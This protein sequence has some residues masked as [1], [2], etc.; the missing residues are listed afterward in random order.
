LQNFDAPDEVLVVLENDVEISS[1]QQ[2]LWSADCRYA[3]A[4]LGI[5]GRDASDTYV[6]DVTTGQRVGILADAHEINHPIT[7]HPSQPLLLAETR[8]GALLWYL[9][10]NSQFPLDT[11]AETALTG[12]P[13]VRNFSAYSWSNDLFFI[14]PVIA[15]DT[16]GS[17]T[18]SRAHCSMLC[19]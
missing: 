10:T 12:R 16:Y 17:T 11:G 7:W 18:S 9:P 6:W 3:A 4:S 5:V 13:G 14:V 2:H 1:F 15:P 8:N 19:L